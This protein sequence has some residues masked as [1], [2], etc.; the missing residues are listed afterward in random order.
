MR[1]FYTEGHKI[2]RS[3]CFSATQFQVWSYTLNYRCDA[4]GGMYLVKNRYL[5][6]QQTE[7]CDEAQFEIT[8]NIYVA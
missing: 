6:T 1:Y 4:A 3:Y 2:K 8:L 7:L 5:H